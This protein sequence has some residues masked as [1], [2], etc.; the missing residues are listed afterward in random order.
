MCG[1]RASKSCVHEQQFMKMQ[2]K[3]PSCVCCVSNN[4][5]GESA[6][7]GLKLTDHVC[8]SEDVG[9][10]LEVFL[11]LMSALLVEMAAP[12]GHRKMRVTAHLCPMQSW[13]SED[14][15]DR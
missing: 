4:A 9:V 2:G 15:T 12:A 7:V 1:S 10:Y 3:C 11:L 8:I 13:S 6:I 14:I 5:C